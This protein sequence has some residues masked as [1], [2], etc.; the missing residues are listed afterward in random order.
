MKQLYLQGRHSCLSIAGS[1]TIYLMKTFTFLL[2]FMLISTISFAQE[3]ATVSIE[4]NDCQD[5]G[6]EITS[7]SFDYEFALD[8][9]VTPDFLGTSG[10]DIINATNDENLF[11]FFISDGSPSSGSVILDQ[12]DI[13]GSSLCTDLVDGLAIETNFDFFGPNGFIDATATGV[14]SFPTIPTMGQWALLILGLIMTSLGVVFI[15]R[16]VVA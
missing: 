11:F 13:N 6:V 15:K 7:L 3:D 4:I 8:D 10:F 12:F 1:K 16:K 14:L 2:T 5:D 9:E